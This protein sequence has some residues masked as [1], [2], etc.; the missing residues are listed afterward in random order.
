MNFVIKEVAGEK[1]TWIF[2]L[3]ALLMAV[4]E[5]SSQSLWIDEG[6]AT[7]FAFQEAFA[8]VIKTL[9]NT[10]MAESLIPGYVVYMWAWV[11]AFGT[12]EYSLRL[13]NLPFIVLVLLL[14]AKLPVNRVFKN[15][16][17]IFTGFS[18]L[19]LY[20]VNEVRSYI[21]LFFFS[22]I[23]LVGLLFY[24]Y[25]DA[26]QKKTGPYLTVF[27][28][29]IGLFFNISAGF[30]ILALI[31]TAVL[32]QQPIKESQRNLL[33]D[34]KK[35][36]FF[37][38]PLFVG[39]GGFYGWVISAGSGGRLQESGAGPTLKHIVFCFYEFLG[40]TGLGPPRN[41]IREDPSLATFAPYTPWLGLAVL[42]VICALAYILVSYRQNGKI[43]RFFLNPYMWGFL[44]GFLAFCLFAFSAGF[45][46]YGRHVIVLYPFFIF[47]VACM[48]KD[49]WSRKS[50]LKLRYSLMALLLMVFL[51]SALRLRFDPA[52]FKDD[53]RSAAS[54]ALSLAGENTPV[55]WAA[56][57]HAGAY[58]G[59]ELTDVLDPE[60]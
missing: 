36:L 49:V 16:I 9:K 12:S 41:V 15:A 3:F 33:R 17:L 20:Y 57:F 21:A 2:C 23:G 53:Y 55:F 54:T 46:F 8:D 52:Y 7:W 42:V 6:I 35:P 11:K 30:A 45:V 37:A 1:W 13:A 44:A 29:L 39:L 19:I 5:I 22:A 56:D 51:V 43:R 27:G 4:L 18:P 14:F 48:V 59:L 26:T 31:P 24:F 38:M 58:Y 47:A 34:W 25:G 32:I 60:R 28:L 10:D 40:F 50:R